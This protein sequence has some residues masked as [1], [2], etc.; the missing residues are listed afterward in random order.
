MTDNP[1]VPSDAR[2]LLDLAEAA[3]YLNDSP[4]HVRSL[5]ERRQ[6]AAIRV[7]RKVRFDPRDLERYIEARRV[8]PVR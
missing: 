3:R 1:I 7:G 4:R 8:E 2:R 5:W 6:I